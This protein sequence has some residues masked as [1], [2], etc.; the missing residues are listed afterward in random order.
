MP[1][2]TFSGVR[3]P[4]RTKVLDIASAP[5]PVAELPRPRAREPQRRDSCGPKDSSIAR[6]LCEDP[7]I[8]SLDRE[9]NAAFAAAMR[10]SATP[11]QLAID[12]ESWILRRDRTARED[13]EAIGDLYRE[14]IAVL[15][16][17]T[18]ETAPGG[19]RP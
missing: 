19:E 7:Q 4:A 13:P 15:Q 9:V 14:R 17:R 16:D 2:A 18:G 10:E 3:P 5:P 11:G 6:I 8:A 1:V 12:Q